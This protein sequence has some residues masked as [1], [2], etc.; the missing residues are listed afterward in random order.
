MIMIAAMI[1]AFVFFIVFFMYVFYFKNVLHL[2]DSKIEL[3]ASEF[4]NYRNMNKKDQ[5]MWVSMIKE[6]ELKHASLR[7]ECLFY[8]KSYLEGK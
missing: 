6:L 1:I 8:F 4:H 7:K 2:L 5:E 3:R